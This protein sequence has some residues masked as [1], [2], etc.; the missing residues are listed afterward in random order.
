MLL[1]QT[2]FMPV[3]NIQGCG[4]KQGLTVH[5]KSSQFPSTI[6]AIP[7]IPAKATLFL[8]P[9]EPSWGGGEIQGRRWVKTTCKAT[10]LLKEGKQSLQQKLVLPKSLILKKLPWNIKTEFFFPSSSLSSE[11]KKKNQSYANTQ[12]QVWENL[13]RTYG[14]DTFP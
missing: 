14:T 1:T 7:H 12:P 11:L 2:E 4:W 13:L 5:A 8:L 3:N 9:W 10:F 6:Y